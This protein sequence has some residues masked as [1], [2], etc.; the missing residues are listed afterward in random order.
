MRDTLHRNSMLHSVLSCEQC[1][2]I[3]KVRLK[4]KTEHRSQPEVVRQN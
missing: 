4:E 1:S 3:A 2:V